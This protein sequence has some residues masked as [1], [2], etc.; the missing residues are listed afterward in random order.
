MFR[1]IIRFAIFAVVI[2]LSLYVGVQWKL[3]EDLNYLTSKLRPFVQFDY[4]SSA[5]T[6]TGTIV[7]TDI[8]LFFQQQDI[9]ITID[10]IEY[11]G[12]SILDMAFFR[13]QINS[14]QIP[15]KISLKVQQAVIPL[16]PSLVKYISSA[17]QNSIW[18]AL[19]ATGCGKIKHIGINQ[20]FSMGYDYIVFSSESNFRQD[21]YS[22]NLVGGGWLDIEDT[23]KFSYDIN[24]AGFYQSMNAP[25]NESQLPTLEQLTFDIQDKGYNHHR[26]NYCSSRIGLKGDEYVEQHVEIVSQKLESVGIKMTLA[27]K[28]HYSSFRQPSSLLHLSVQPTVSFSIADFGYYDEPQLRK[29]LGL[30]LQV[31]HQTVGTLFNNWALD[32]FEKIVVRDPEEEQSVDEQPRYK[33]VFIKRTFQKHPLSS[34]NSFVNEKVRLIRED[35]KK[36]EG[37]LEE[38]KNNKLYVAMTLQGGIVTVTV[39]VKSVREFLVYQ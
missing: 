19:N 35:G 26:N 7:V 22:G 4:Q 27:G 2:G 28:R 9:N 16:T 17:E 11:S 14:R 24:L 1:F 36:F 32:K 21:D 30:E 33:T 25:L 3:K 31:N 20:Y 13:R 29:L 12:G 5:M 37:K 23:I 15:Q 39:D 18:N 6:L 34:I 10:K 8:D 38:I